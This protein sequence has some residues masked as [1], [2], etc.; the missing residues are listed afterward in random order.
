MKRT[1]LQLTVASLFMAIPASYALA[2]NANETITVDATKRQLVSFETLFESPSLS[3]ATLSPNGKMLAVIMQVKGRMALGVMDLEKNT[4]KIAAASPDWDVS[5]PAWVNN[6]RLVFSITDSKATMSENAGGGLFAVNADGSKGITL[7]KSAKQ[8]EVDGDG[9]YRASQ[10]VRRAGGDSDDILVMRNERYGDGNAHKFGGADMFLMDTKTGKSKMLTFDSPGAM[11]NWVVDNSNQVRVGYTL[12]GDKA[13]GKLKY[14][15]YYRDNNDSPWKKISE[16]IYQEEEGY[17]PVG[18]DADNKTMYVVGR[19]MKDDTKGLYIWDFATNKP[20]ELVLRHPRADMEEDAGVLLR[21]ATG[22][23]VGAQVDA[24][25][26]ESFFFD[27]KWAQAHA[28]LQSTFPDATISM[29]WRGDRILVVARSS[30]LPVQY[31]LMDPKEKTIQPLPASY[32]NLK[33]E[34]MST[35]QVTEY[36]A[37]DGMAIPAY[38]TLPV[39]RTPKNLPLVAYVHGGPHARD[40]FGFNPTV[41]ALASRGYAVF[42][43]QFRMST[44]LG[45]KLHHSGWKQWG[46]AMQDDVTDGVKD[47]I[48]QGI[49]DPKRVC[50]MGASYGGYAA[51]YGLIKDPDFYQCGI[52]YVGVTDV[53]LLFNVSWSDTAGGAWANYAQKDLHGDPEKDLDYMH[54]SSA[55]ENADKLKKPLMMAYGSE[56]VRVPLIHGEKMRDKLRAQ[57]NTVEWMV[58]T[59]E[60]HGWAKKENKIKFANS[61]DTF[62]SKYIGDGAPS[63]Q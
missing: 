30:T 36:K 59:G 12:E 19:S 1:V 21:D 17:L 27:D 11:N 37:R 58:F 22:A 33:A 16:F 35:M 45:W 28:M 4:T 20:K 54:K 2:A 44:G 62:L 40:E 23:V 26:T 39:G 34:Q 31:Y 32:P 52:N 63:A 56:D 51:T 3:G 41:Q 47:L 6:N 38:L 55:I 29:S 50:I 15:V 24:M 25:K 49:V 43:P 46:L 60:G 7:S 9:R 57:G 18:F 10:F 42:Q 14:Y 53:R 61:V 48:K 8:V 13:S 5:S